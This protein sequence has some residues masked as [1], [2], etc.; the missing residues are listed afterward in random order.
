MAMFTA[1]IVALLAFQTPRDT[2]AVASG[3]GVWDAI[4]GFRAEWVEPILTSCSAAFH[5]RHS[6][7]TGLALDHDVEIGGA[8]RASCAASRLHARWC[9]R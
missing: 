2:L 5:T 9:G 7:D 4:A 3:K 1:G 6:R 8:G